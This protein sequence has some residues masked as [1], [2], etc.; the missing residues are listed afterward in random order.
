[1]DAVEKIARTC[2]YE[3]YLLWPYR[4]SALKNQQRWTFGGIYP[5]DRAD[6]L[7]E[8][9]TM[10]TQCL[11]EAGP[12]A[13][14][15][16]SVRFLH[17]VDRAV[18]RHGPDG[19]QPVDSLTVDG[20][21]H[22]SWQE[23]TERRVELP[24]ATVSG[25]LD[26]PRRTALDISG[27]TAH[28][29]LTDHHGILAGELVRS[30][31]PLAGTVETRADRVDEAT[32]RI[33]VRIT[34][35]TACPPPGAAPAATATRDGTAAH[36][37]LSGHTV[38]HC[39]RGRFVSLIDPPDGLREAAQACRNQGTWPVLVGGEGRWG[40]TVLSS[41]ITLYDHPAVAPESPGDLFDG[42]EIDQLLILSVL[43]MSDEE[44]A[45]MAACDPR[46][47]AILRR[48]SELTPDDLMAL[49]GAIRAKRP[50]EDA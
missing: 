2:L 28:E 1:M 16:V 22:L 39:E 32:V 27:G 40:R 15:A 4:R 18:L 41:P 11:L 5:Q 10:E 47:D 50:L 24:P 49:H 14:V 17:L 42:T 35:T 13:V 48:C 38:L 26:G 9:D 45:E 6:L 12:E 25:L 36:A 3:G 33:S 43:S 20:R 37:L 44:R 19:P 23:A 21:R 30:W 29:E 34:N 31:Q 7:G 46:A 8:P